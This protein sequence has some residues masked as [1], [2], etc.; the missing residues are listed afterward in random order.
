MLRLVRALREVFGDRVEDDLGVAGGRYERVLTGI[1]GLERLRANDPGLSQLTP[2]RLDLLDFFVVEHT[3]RVPDL[4][5]YLAL[6]DFAAA[7]VAADPEARLTDAVASPSVKLTCTTLHSARGEQLTRYV[8]SLPFSAAI[9]P[10]HVASTLWATARAAKYFS[11]I[12]GADR[13]LIGRRVLHLGLSSVWDQTHQEHLVALMARVIAEGADVTDLDLLAAYELKGAGAFDQGALLTQGSTVQGFNWSGTLA[14]NGIAWGSVR[15]VTGSRD[16]GITVQPVEQLW[17][18]PGRPVPTLRVVEVDQ[19]GSVV[20]HLPGRLPSPVPDS[21]YLALLSL[22]PVLSMQLSLSV[23]VLFLTTGPGALS[24]GLVQQF[25]Q[26]TGRPTFGYSAPMMLTAPCP[27]DPLN[28]L[29]LPDAATGA[30]GQWTAATR[31][32]PT[33]R[34]AAAQTGSVT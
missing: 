5:G 13:E 27:G 29:T 3:G 9:T 24:Q 2:F 6:L 15:Q 23:P 18:G 8:Q 31:Q 7:A 26:R 16:G 32:P 20:V 34:P 12:V 22:D 19:S 30:F 10:R 33:I 28:I 17:T 21:E 4:E 25:S 14:L 11:L 1:V